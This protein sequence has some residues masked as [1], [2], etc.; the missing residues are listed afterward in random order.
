[1][2]TNPNV[3][4]HETDREAMQALKAIP[5]F[6]QVTKSFLNS[7]S[8]KMMYMENIASNIR[9]TDEQLPKYKAMRKARH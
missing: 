6:S 2:K 3:F 9:I 1:M 4:I 7:W 8:E 5:G